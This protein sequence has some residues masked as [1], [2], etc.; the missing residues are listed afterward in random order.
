LNGFCI[1]GNFLRK[2]INYLSMF[3]L[4]NH[5][6]AFAKYVY[7]FDIYTFYLFRLVK[8]NGWT[9]VCERKDSNVF[10]TCSRN[11]TYITCFPCGLHELICMPLTQVWYTKRVLYHF[12]SLLCEIH[13]PFKILTEISQFS[14]GIPRVEITYTKHTK[15]NWSS[16]W[17]SVQNSLYQC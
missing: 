13:E 17:G 3:Y 11:I 7:L 15:Q 10:L 9:K 6:G 4:S 14:R 8:L 1:D 2:I 12:I 16:W 5:E